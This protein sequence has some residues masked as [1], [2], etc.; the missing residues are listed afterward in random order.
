MASTEDPYLILPGSSAHSDFR[1]QRLAQAIG[2]KEVRSLWVHFVNPLKELSDEELKTLQQIL[3]YGEYPS[4]TDRL[5]Q[6]LIDAINRGGEPRDDNTVLF[7]VCPRAGTI[8]PWSSLAS[9][10]ARTCTLEN[11]VKR[12]ERGMVIAATFDNVPGA[13]EIP[14]RDH[15]Y[16]RMTQTIS[17][18]AP[19]LEAIFGESEPAQATTISFDEYSSAHAALE[20][21]NRELGLAMDKSEIE[22]LV[23]AYT[24]ELKRGPV[25][26]ELFMFAQVNSEHCRHK[27]FN[28]DFTVDGMHKPMSLF[29]M[30]RNTHKQHPQHVISAYSDNAAVLAGE[31]ASFWAPND[32]TGEWNGTKETVHI[33]CKVETHNH[34]TAVSPFPGAAT[35]SGGEIR[36][37]GA[38]GRGSK[39][40]AGLAGFTVSDLLLEGFE[41]PWELKDVGKPAHIA[42]SKDIM[43]EAPIGS[44][45]FNNEFGR[46]CTVGY[47]R[48]ML[49]R[50][51]TN[52]KE[53]EIRGYHKPIMLAGGVG[54]VRPQHALK[55]PDIVPAGSHLLVIGGPA[56]LIGLGGGAAS[57]I[58]SGEGKVDL[59]FASVQRGNP[60]VQ[61]RAQEVIDTCRSMGDSNP[62]LFI[63]DVGAGGLSNALPELVH[64]SGLGAIFELREIDNV[65][66]GMSPLQIWCCEAQERY[67]LAV[68]PDQLDLFK[69]ICHRE[70]CGYSVVGKATKEQRLVLTDRDS[71]ENPTPIDLPMETLFGKP[72]KMSRIVETRKLR[73]PAFDS[74]LSMYIPDTP[75]DGLVAEAVDRVLTLPSVGSKSFLITIGDRT[76]GGLTA[77][78]QMVGK[79]QTPVADVSVTA[80]SL[81][82]GVKTGEAMSMGEK[83][84]LALISPAASARMAVAESL[85]NIAAASLFDRL[86][87]VRLSAN[88]MSASS[89]PGEGAALYEA[90]EAIGMDLCPKLGIS[91]PVGKDSM[92]MKMK[93][94]DDG[95]AKEVTA[96]MSLVITAFAPVDRIDRTWTPALERLESVG[97][98]VIMYVDLAAGKK[99]LGGS[100]L[101]QTFGQVGDEAPDVYDADIIKDYFDAIE[102]LHESGVVLAYHDRSDGGLFTTL[103]E[104]AFAGRC[105]LEVMLDKVAASSEPKD[106]L[107]ALFNEELG[108]VFQIRKKDE[109]AFN[110]CFATC[111]PPPG[112]IRKIGRVPEASKQDISFY[113]G[114]QNVYRNSRSKL[115]QRWAETSYRMQK[116]RDNPVCADAEFEKILDNKDPGLSYNLTFK[117]TENI[118]PLMSNL[119]SPFT[120]K[121]RVAVLRE[122]GVNGQAEMAFAFHQAGFSAID[123]HMTDIV[124]SRVSLAGFVGLAACG[125][126]SYGDV[127]GAGQGWAKSVLLHPNTRK[128]FQSFFARPDTF[129]LGVCNGC[130]FMSKLKE[131]I[132]G[133]ELWP[134]FE[135]NA[136]EQYEARVCMVEVIDP[137]GPNTSPS[138]FLHGMN[139]SKL[140][141]VTAHGEGRAHFSSS[142]TSPSTPQALYQE[143][144]VSLRYVDN[145]GQQTEAYPYNPNGSPLGITGVRS[146]DGRVLALMPHPER[147]ILKEVGSYIP[148]DTEG[149]VVYLNWVNSVVY[150]VPLSYVT[151]I[152]LGINTLGV[153][154]QMVLT[155]DAY[156]IKNH[157][158][159]F[160]QCAA[161]VCLA[162][163]T[164]LQYTELREAAARIIK[165]QDMYNTPFAKL[166]WPFWKKTSPGLMVYLVLL[167]YTPYF[168]FAFIFIYTF[169]DVHF[170]QPEFSLTIAIMPAI[171]LHVG[172]AVYTVRHEKRFVMTVVLLG[173]AAYIAYLVSRLVVLYGNSQLANTWMKDQMVFYV[174]VG[175]GFSVITLVVGCICLWNFNKGLKPILLGQVQRK[176]RPNEVETDYYVQRLNYNIVPLADRD[177]Q[178][179]ALD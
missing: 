156:R 54:T 166:E 119:R 131:L 89:H 128:E 177:S 93:W 19:N 61:R 160:V 59:D 51:F 49:M 87:R 85:M 44:A 2:A 144:L 88:W 16:D 26:V 148:R 67:V 90:V 83:P 172:I 14:N 9:M 62:I 123:V 29:G 133:A 34:P 52:E 125:G 138:V 174:C 124:S 92:S 95:E 22:Y 110:R 63:H 169:I 149:W 140:P 170:T 39:P 66:K 121:P 129:A 17:R 157:I 106:V 76:V 101:A 64:D 146:T 120:A 94:S 171:L 91:I 75:K 55:D 111:G 65:D 33:L 167:K 11:A 136:S 38:V 127:L 96:P 118:I 5:S 116:L 147:T 158:Q 27:Q 40:K 97:E 179:F 163:S 21:A 102:Q 107:E 12:I 151:P 3:H 74:T 155:L 132:P 7:Y 135:R 113:V 78:D 175:L 104:M 69:R 70:R 115:Q 173:H 154:Y 159:I 141:I 23:E 1:L 25:D 100:A 153:I 31:E 178:R 82:A 134:S 168:I 46:P 114:T 98:T 24:Q 165:G 84:T 68:A 8:S 108:A 137:K 13:D 145:Y 99:H 139:G 81:L 105:G 60:E 53:S 45:Q 73:L 71:K 112:M 10:I 36:D 32:L 43:L 77:R 109:T 56:M 143:N 20:H 58:Q 72:P 150:Q 79:W 35:G 6:T 86:S 164:V 4:S 103:V 42:S 152:T 47:F 57:S 50:V 117:P 126:F 15:L 130:Q 37:E 176:I 161:N 28:A 162:V 30:I 80:T 142:A 48:T 122:E 18:Q 41:R